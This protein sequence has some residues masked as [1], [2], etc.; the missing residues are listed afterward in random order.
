MRKFF[1]LLLLILLVL[2]PSSFAQKTGKYRINFLGDTV[3]NRS[4]I[5]PPSGLTPEQEF[6]RTI[7]AKFPTPKIN[8]NPEESPKFWTIGVLDE[9]GFSQVSLT[10]WAAGGEGSIALNAYLNAMANYLKGKIFWDNRLQLGYGFVQSFDVGY[11]KADDRIVLDSKLGYKAYKK[12]Y[13]SAAFNFRSQFSPGFDYDKNNVGTMKSKFL[14]PGYAYLGIGVDYK[15]GDGKVLT[16]SFSPL[17]AGLT[18]V[19]ADSTLRVKYGNQYDR[20]FRWELGAQF[21]ATFQK[22]FGKNCKVASQFSLFSDYMGD[23]DNIVI[24]WDFQFDYIINRYFKAALRT[25]LLY[26]DKIKITSKSGREAPR[27]QFKEVFSLNFSY[28]IGEFKK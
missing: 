27:V 21:T 28:T 6:L 9:I 13:L 17:T 8:Y 23:A 1:P 15:P 19:N 26:D 22:T 18:I 11:R 7:G 3:K 5:P 2:A 10:N 25:N 24:H 12:F 4:Y 16:L 14:A 20:L